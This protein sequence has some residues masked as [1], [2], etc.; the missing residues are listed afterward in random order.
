MTVRFES[1][2]LGHL[3]RSSQGNLSQQLVDALA[4]RIKQGELKSGDRFPT[5]V[6]L[7]EQYGVSRTV[8]REAIAS[9]KADGLVETRHGIG[10][11]VLDPNQH[12]R[13]ATDPQEVQSI[14][15]ALQ[16][17]ELRLCLEPESAALA[18]SNRTDDELCAIRAA[19]DEVNEHMRNGTTSTT[20]DYEFHRTICH[21][22]G[23][24]YFQSALEFLGSRAI[25]R[26][27]VRTHHY[28]PLTRNQYMEHVNLEHERIYSAI[29]NRQ[30]DEARQAM[31]THLQ[32][33]LERL[34]QAI[35]AE[36]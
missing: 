6:E 3:G 21:A 7:I 33:S 26:A 34:R 14:K 4:D 2:D 25:P 22:S 5:E 12:L 23:N 13:I 11:F 36:G 18:A 32:G 27:Q 30:P 17:L 24:Q 1:T 20:A 16:M 31:Q 28:Q 10:T 8:V 35:A 9:L 19:L 29:A 15:E